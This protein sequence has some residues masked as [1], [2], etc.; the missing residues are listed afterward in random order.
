MPRTGPA[1]DLIT[2][3][4]KAAYRHFGLERRSVLIAVS[5]GADSTALL[6][7]TARV[8]ERL[9]LTVEVAT[10][11]H[12]LRPEAADEARAVERLAALHGFV[13][14]VRQLHLRA[15][16]GVEQRA[17]EARYAALEALRSERGLA[18]VAT[19]HTAADQAETLL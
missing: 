6:V 9:G 15:G 19:A 10:L 2:R 18:A 4:L 5:G 11:D 14:H 16:A 1:T 7:G 8:S 13:C 17:R 12:G 3:T